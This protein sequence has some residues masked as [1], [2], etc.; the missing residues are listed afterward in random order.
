MISEAIS[1]FN[2]SMIVY[3]CG[4]PFRSEIP[5]F[6]ETSVKGSLLQ[7]N[8]PGHINRGCLELHVYCMSVTTEGQAAC[9]GL[10][11]C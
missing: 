1:S 7:P 9:P 4:K 11:S 2:D 10:C 5:G 8:L 6:A 3:T